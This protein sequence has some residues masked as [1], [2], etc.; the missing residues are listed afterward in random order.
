MLHVEPIPRVIAARSIPG[1]RPLSTR[2]LQH[3][4]ERRRFWDNASP[5]EILRADERERRNKLWALGGSVGGSWG[6]RMATYAATFRP[7]KVG[8]CLRFG[9][10]TSASDA[11][12]YPDR[13]GHGHVFVQGTPGERPA[14]D[15]TGLN[16]RPALV[17]DGEND[18]LACTT[19]FAQTLMGGTN[20]PSTQILVLRVITDDVISSFFSCYRSNTSLP[21]WAI[22]QHSVGSGVWYLFKRDDANSSNPEPTGGS[23]GNEPHIL[24]V[25]T[26][27]DG[28][29]RVY[30]NGAPVELNRD[31]VLTGELTLDRAQ[32]GAD[33]TAAFGHFALA[34]DAFFTR[35]VTDTERLYLE[36]GYAA[37]YGLTLAA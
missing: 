24:V 34:A 9:H 26:E 13:T 3:A 11:A 28:G 29:L 6:G 32:F 22:K 15:E 18:V 21:R 33:R 31:D 17:F 37:R 30:D 4:L 20:A 1:V 35:A 5:A 12:S 10:V 16:G 27:A 23:V 36:R 8:G 14:F 19:S 2:G 25:T 7:D